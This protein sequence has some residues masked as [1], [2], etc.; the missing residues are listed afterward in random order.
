MPVVLLNWTLIPIGCVIYFLH[1]TGHHST[2]QT[3]WNSAFQSF[4]LFKGIG[5][6]RSCF[7]LSFPRRQAYNESNENLWFLFCR[8]NP[9]LGDHYCR[10]CSSSGQNLTMRLSSQ[11]NPSSH[12][13]INPDNSSHTKY[14][15][16][17]IYDA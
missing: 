8:R 14:C 7:K 3:G 11:P 6:R 4:E 12:F 13:L 2:F 9:A 10:P 1:V 16:G 5:H 17:I 15:Q